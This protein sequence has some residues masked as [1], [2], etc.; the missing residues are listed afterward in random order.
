MAAKIVTTT[1]DQTAV[2]LP[3]AAKPSTTSPVALLAALP[4]AGL[5]IFAALF[6]PFVSGFP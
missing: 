4:N 6:F 1:A 5:F 2:A 3:Y